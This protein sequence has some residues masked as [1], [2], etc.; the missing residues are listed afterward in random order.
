MEPRQY[1]PVAKALK[2]YYGYDSFRP[3]QLDLIH[4]LLDG[5]D[6]L[7]I[8]PT[9]AGKSVCFQIPAIFMPGIT[10]VISPLISL[11]K[12]QVAALNQAG[13]PAAYLNSS[14]T[15]AQYKKALYLAKMGKYKI[16]YVAPERLNTPGFL[17]FASSVT[18]SMIAVDEA[19]CVS[20]WGQNFR[21]TY[22]EIPK[23][24]AAL[25]QRPVMAAFTA[26]ATGSVREDMIRQ[27]DLH[28]PQLLV[29][30][31]D[32]KNLFFDVRQPK[33]KFSALLRF[34]ED[35]PHE[36]GVIYC[37]TR[38]ETEEI[39]RRL[40]EQGYPCT[41]YHAGLSN[42]E[43]SQNQDDFLYDRVRLI[44]ATSAFGMGIDKSNVRFVVHYAMPPS[45]EN[46]Y[47]E[48]GRA[49]RDGANAYC[50]LLYGPGDWNTNKFLI[51]NSNEDNE[52]Q[53]QWD[54][55]R[56]RAMDAYCKT[57]MCLRSTLLQY[58]GE[59]SQGHCD[60]CSNC[61]SSWIS[62]DI[63][64]EATT[65]LK[66]L[67]ELPYAYGVSTITE[68]LKG[69]DREKIRSSRLNTISSYGALKDLTARR[70]R[71]ILDFLLIKG[72]LIRSD[73]HYQTIRASALFE[74]AIGIKETIEMKRKHEGH[75]SHLSK[76]AIHSDDSEKA[77]TLFSQL[78][79]LR[80]KIA[81]S[82]SLPPYLVFSD[83]TL[84]EMVRH[85]PQSPAQM[86]EINGVGPVKMKKYGQ[87][88]L[89]LICESARKEKD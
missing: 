25:A 7:G 9:G 49:G 38:K 87:P 59:S 66:C 17:D 57:P 35:H 83:S 84:L 71:L 24:A 21:P 32:R 65:I 33:D 6:V 85:K 55:N 63:T 54:M 10:L 20:Q 26:T 48:A 23:F 53:L 30:G 5:K 78:R 45:L 81:R 61:Q 8:M 34:L 76:P 79:A 52:E 42:E 88:F 1:P 29:T 3:G 80:T 82:L 36:S 51:E 12:D 64:K 19:H 46:Y 2:K 39:C 89:D 40:N 41:R 31:F 74:Q 50:L 56:L 75:E 70:I 68:V 86:L 11:M 62:E 22:L 13:I 43:R 16:I 69:S 14:L 67:H 18:I 28:D 27:L 15:F 47:Q 58:F 44:T 72:Y 60:A 73:D 4:A 77:D 37:L